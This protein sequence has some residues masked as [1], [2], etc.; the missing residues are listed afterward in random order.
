MFKRI[1]PFLFLSCMIAAS[2]YAVADSKLEDQLR[3]KLALL[4]P[5]EKPDS[6][7]ASAIGGLYEVTYGAQ[8]VYISEDGRY[9]IQ[10]TML[11]VDDRRNLTEESRTTGRKALMA[12]LKD[13][14]TVVFAPK[15]VKHT[16]TVFTDVDCT[17]CRKLHGEMSELNKLGIKVRY[18]A[19]PRA[20]ENSPTYNKM[21]SV[22]CAKD[23]NDAMNKAKAGK[24]V[25][26]ANCDN[27]ISSQFSLGQRA[28]VN[29]TPAIVLESGDLIPG[30]RPAADLAALLEQMA[31]SKP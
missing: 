8:V 4:L 5:D 27:P 29:G 10:G 7:R 21:V 3:Q 23:R 11:D 22:W 24:A 2:S 6:V 16:I 1:L 15:D 25:A 28:G 30:Y 14:Q 17:Y 13:S 31:A 19:F 12:E 20:G 26:E 9:L 18:V